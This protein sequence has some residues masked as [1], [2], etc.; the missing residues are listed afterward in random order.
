M[1]NV[2]LRNFVATATLVF[3]CFLL[4]AVS[5]VGIGRGYIIND[6]RER[7]DNNASEVARTASA[8]AD[9]DSLTSWSLSMTLSSISRTTGNQV[10]ITDETGKIVSCSDRAPM[11]EHLGH[12]IPADVMQTLETTGE[13]DQMST[14]GGLYEK[15]RYAVARPIKTAADGN[16]IIGYV[17]ITNVVDNILKTWSSLTGITA[18]VTIGVFAAAMI[19][20]LMYSKHMAKPLDEMAAASRRF[21]RGD[22]SVRVRQRED[23]TDEMGALIDSFNKMADSLE[24]AEARR[25]EFIANISH[26]LR[27]PMTTISG[28]A[29]GLLDGTIPPEDEKKYLRA[30]SDETKRLSRLVRDMLD[31]SQLRNRAADPTKRIDFDL[32]ELTLQTLLSFESRAT[33]KNLDV[34]PQLP[35]NHIMVHADKDAITQ[36]IYNLLDNAVKFATPGSC[37]T[38]RIYKDNGKAYVSVRDY[39]ET[40][41]PDDLP[42]IFDRFHKSDRSRSLDKD[43]VGLGLYLVKSIINSHDEDIAVTS[44]DGM[45]EFVFTLTLAKNEPGEKKTNLF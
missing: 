25:S 20:S 2:Y 17:F 9:G 14:L 45:T 26:E 8:I 16:D 32:T 43:G 35:D 29:E 41:P 21:A 40:I 12:Q 11:C 23:P 30:I 4:V 15:N 33:K 39:G 3:M 28:F 13:Y 34:D 22:F 1:K 36:V 24:N 10:F 37:I 42:F 27:T 31:V 18:I 6:Y 44:R 38:V 19:V 7:M 5:F